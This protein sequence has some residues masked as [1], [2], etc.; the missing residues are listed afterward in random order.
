MHV[1][2][3]CCLSAVHIPVALE[4]HV[5]G[6]FCRGCLE[7]DVEKRVGVPNIPPKILQPRKTEKLL[8]PQ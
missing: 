6:N 1:P 3:S 8:I 7:A 2:H 5:R 4:D